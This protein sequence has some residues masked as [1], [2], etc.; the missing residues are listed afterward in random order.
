VK[1]EDD[2]SLVGVAV[3]RVP[4]ANARNVPTIQALLVSLYDNVPQ[5]MP[6]A[7]SLPQFNLNFHISKPN[8]I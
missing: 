7:T 8:N 2:A 3:T 6:L 4:H 1:I 5:L